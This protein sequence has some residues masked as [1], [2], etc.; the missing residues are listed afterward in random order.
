MKGERVVVI[1]GPSCRVRGDT[2]PTWLPVPFMETVLGLIIPSCAS[3]SS[4]WAT[5]CVPVS[6]ASHFHTDIKVSYKDVCVRGSVRTTTVTC[7][8]DTHRDHTKERCMPPFEFR[9]RSRH[10]NQ[11]QNLIV[12]Q[13]HCLPLYTIVLFP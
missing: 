2:G 1:P 4:S 7:T 6:F 12:V 10:Q 11:L 9:P 13:M 3:S 5:L 8:R